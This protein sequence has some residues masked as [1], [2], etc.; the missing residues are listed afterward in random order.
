MKLSRQLHHQL[1]SFFREFFD[2]EKL[3]LPEIEIYGNRGARLATKILSVHGI[4]FGRFIFI[5]PDL[6]RRDSQERL[7]ISKE[8]LAHEAAHVLQYQQ[9]GAA[10]F[11]YKYF[12][13]YFAALK[14][15]KSWDFNSRA[16]AYLE[17]PFE[18]EARAGGAEFVELVE[19]ARSAKLEIS[20]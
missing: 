11:L 3:R 5:K 12:K 1:E 17:I 16:E 6:I 9:L 10:K 19:K 13:S 14:L 18:A 8:L 2:D 4:S 20:S 7:C 15:K